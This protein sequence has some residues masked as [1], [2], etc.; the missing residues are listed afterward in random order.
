MHLEIHLKKILKKQ[1]FNKAWNSIQPKILEKQAVYGVDTV[2]G[3]TF[4]SNGILKAVQKALELGF[5]SV[6]LDASTLPF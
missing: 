1:N 3:A 2:S 5:T 4:S 6:M